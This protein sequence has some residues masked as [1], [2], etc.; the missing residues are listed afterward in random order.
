MKKDHN[1]DT[2]RQKISELKT[3]IMYDTSN[4][5][6]VLPNTLVTALQVDNEGQLWFACQN[7][8]RHV[9]SGDKEF[10]P[11]LHFYRKN[12]PY[13]LKV[14]GKAR[15]MNIIRGDVNESP[16]TTGMDILL[17]KMSMN[18]IEYVEQTER[19]SRNRIEQWVENGYNWLLR[20]IAI[21]APKHSLS[22]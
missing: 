14:N 1:L 22:R 9:P 18:T 8:S 21:P 12:I 10:S 2:I 13:H 19:R 11:R 20:H 4:D 16:G 7:F 5:E 3:A 6:I 15:L 17:F